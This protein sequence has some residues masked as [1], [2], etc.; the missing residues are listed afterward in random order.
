MKKINIIALLIIVMMAGCNYKSREEKAAIE[1]YKQD[2]IEKT[3]L[4][5]YSITAIKKVEED[6]KE[7]KEWEKTPAGKIQKKH[8]EWSKEDCEGVAEK[9][10]WI[11]M[12]IQM[13][14]Y[15][16][17][18]PNHKN[19][20]NYGNGNEY[21]YCWDNYSISCFYTKADQIVYAYN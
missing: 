11:G 14:V 16:R 13:V 1:K 6:S 19:V 20:S 12:D 10:V 5:E 9:N 2:S 4:K 15:N 3:Q 7:Q 17:G 8:P 18:L 21:Q